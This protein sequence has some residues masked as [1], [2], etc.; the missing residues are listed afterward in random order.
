LF[1]FLNLHKPLGCTSHDCVAQIRRLAQTRRVGHGGT[2]DPLASGVLPLA[3]GQATRLLPY[4][5]KT[6]SYH[7]VIRFGLTTTTDDLAGEI[8]QQHPTKDLSLAEIQ[9]HLPE[10]LG[11]VLQIPPQYSA[12]Q[13]NGQRLYALARAGMAV[14]VPPRWVDIFSL[15]IL[16]WRPGEPAELEMEI[17][18]GEGTYIRSLA[19]DWG[20]KVGTGATLAKLVRTLAAGM[21]LEQSWQLA[22]LREQPDDLSRALIMPAQALAHLTQI[23]L[24]E[25]ELKRWFYGQRLLVEPQPPGLRVVMNED[26]SCVGIGEIRLDTESKVLHPQVVLHIP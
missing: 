3:I 10:F 12:I 26:G 18:C 4:L 15:N 1:G 16:E 7:G 9:S 8:L 5:P 2:L 22:S 6:K 21:S 13:K 23:C 11:R 20:Q 24:A 14:A 17:T 19:R 25:P